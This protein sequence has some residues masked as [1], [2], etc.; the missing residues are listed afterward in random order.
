MKSELPVLTSDKPSFRIRKTM[1][2]KDG[3]YIMKK[4]SILKEDITVLSMYAPNNRSSKSIHQKLI[5][6]Q[7]EID[8]STLRVGEFHAAFLAIEKDSAG[9]KSTRL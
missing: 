8:N 4:G 6:L 3:H 2:D 5:E 1:K 7:R 9:K